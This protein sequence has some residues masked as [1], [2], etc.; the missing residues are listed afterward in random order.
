MSKMWRISGI[1][2]QL[3]HNSRTETDDEEKSACL[4]NLFKKQIFASYL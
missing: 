3:Y 2:G 1:S 4:N